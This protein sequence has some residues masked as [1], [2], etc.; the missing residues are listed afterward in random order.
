VHIYM[1]KHIILVHKHAYIYT[2][3][4]IC[5]YIYIYIYTCTHIY[6][7]FYMYIYIYTY[8]YIHIYIFIAGRLKEAGIVI[9][10]LPAS[11]I[12][13]MARADDGNDYID[14]C[15]YVNIYSVFYLCEYLFTIS[16]E[17]HIYVDI[18]PISFN[19]YL[20]IINIYIKVI[21]GEVY[22]LL[23]SSLSWALALLM[24]RIIYRT[25]SPLRVMVTS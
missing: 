10:A 25:Y 9:L 23:I 11:D 3:T 1:S 2:C 18:D 8:I 15:I 12:C 14:T 20:N 4:L 6:T 16:F 22:A 19:N 13:M 7:Y 24:L 5:I 17:A 21:K